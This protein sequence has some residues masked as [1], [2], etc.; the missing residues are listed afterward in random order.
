[1][2][3]ATCH[4]PE[5]GGTYF[6]EGVNKGQVGVTSADPNQD[7]ERL[8][9]G[10]KTPTN[11]YASFSPKFANCFAGAPAVQPPDGP[12][13]GGNFWNGRAQGND[14]INTAQWPGATKH[15]GYE[16][17]Q[18]PLIDVLGHPYAKYFGPTSDQALNPMPNTVEQNIDRDLVCMEIQE[19]NYA[20][21]YEEVW[22]EEIDCSDNPVTYFAADTGGETEADISFKRLMLAVGAW[23]HSADLNSFSSIR[24]LALQAER[25]CVE[26]APDA[27]PAVCAHEDFAN[28][29]GTFPLV[30]LT[31]EENLGH[32]I[33]YNVNLPF[34]PQFRPFFD[35]TLPASQCAFCH[36]SD[37]SNLDGTG[38][39]E[40]YTDNAYHNIGIPVNPE[41]PADPDPGIAGHAGAP[42]AGGF[43]TPTLR[44]VD[45]RAVEE[46]S[47]EVVFKTKAYGHNGWFKSME[48]IV[49]FYN[50]S[51]A[52]PRCES[53]AGLVPKHEDGFTEEE[54]LANNCWPEPEWPATNSPPFLVG[55]L[56]MEPHE[57]AALVAYLRTLT[58]THTPLAPPPYHGLD[59]VPEEEEESEGPNKPKKKR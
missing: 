45:K 57:E 50:T 55:A 37:G 41:L 39:F 30:G 42:N 38:E 17:F 21:L 3:C 36:L 16:V 43:R 7:G 10:L 35:E 18:A 6:V 22:G 4:D 25:A 59:F 53:I 28:S 46:E 13:C 14:G 24:D 27:D 40:L 32:D 8:I 2:S 5:M 11:T 51:R 15:L 47:G 54:A 44:N 34:A 23:Q 52:K 48:S 56:G 58:D 33:F 29:P 20:P 19:S 12:W 49:H 9:G 1:M 26:G 31:D